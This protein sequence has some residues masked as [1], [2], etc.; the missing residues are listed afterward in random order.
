MVR[1]QRG[2]IGK[3]QGLEA[4]TGSLAGGLTGQQ[5][6]D[7]RRSGTSRAEGHLQKG[8]LTVGW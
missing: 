1:G 2:P 4:G 3:T 8:G 7:G 6:A 5:S